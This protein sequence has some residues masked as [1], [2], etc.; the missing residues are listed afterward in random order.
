MS[1]QLL[2]LYS[3]SFQDHLSFVKLVYMANSHGALYLVFLKIIIPL[4]ADLRFIIVSID[5][6]FMCTVTQDSLCGPA[7]RATP[8]HLLE[9]HKLHFNTITRDAHSSRRSTVLVS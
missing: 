5:S 6:L 7:A 2:C 9:M 1:L 4:M 8:G 3:R